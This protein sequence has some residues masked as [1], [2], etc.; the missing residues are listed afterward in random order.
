MYK[1][2]KNEESD[3]NCKMESVVSRWSCGS[4]TIKEILNDLVRLFKD[5]NIETPRLEAELLFSKAINGKIIHLYTEDERTV[6][7]QELLSLVA[8]VKRRVKME[9]LQYIVGHTEFMSI[10][11]LVDQSVLIPRPETELIVES[12]IEIINSRT[13]GDA[14][15]VNV[16]DI[17]TGCG[18][19]GISIAVM[20]K[21][22]RIFASDISCKALEVAKANAGMNMV[23]ERVVFM[24]GDL[25]EPF[26]AECKD[27][28]A[29]FIVSNPPYVSEDEFDLLG[30]EVANHEPRI[31]LIAGDDG[32][33]FYKRILTDAA[34]WL[35]DGGFLILEI[36][37]KQLDAVID[38]IINVGSGQGLQYIKTVKDLQHINRVM[39]IIR[40][41]K[42]RNRKLGF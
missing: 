14:C 36:G 8:I 27:L 39:V 28:Q 19:I 16:F 26:K 29:D 10:R 30:P 21:G 11:F 35:C 4:S 34:F 7:K 40:K 2:S 41:E 13:S 38:L 1:D 33:A 15:R 6:D 42:R 32:L 22:A 9:P 23:E 25:F 17:C 18:N 12:V 31:S 3:H 37:D 24:H 20:I 5:V